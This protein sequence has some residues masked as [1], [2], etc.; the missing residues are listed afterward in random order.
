MRGCPIQLSTRPLKFLQAL[1][2]NSWAI[3]SDLYQ[4][5]PI[6]WNTFL[7]CT[8][9]TDGE[10]SVFILSRVRV[11]IYFHYHHFNINIRV[12]NISPL[13]AKRILLYLKIQF[14]PHS[15]HFSSRN[16]D[17]LSVSVM[18]ASRIDPE[19]SARNSHYTL[20]YMPAEHNAI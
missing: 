3:T 10:F 18:P 17:W 19:T 1:F 15:K 16:V 9:I 8:R 7:M 20:R 4:I 12:Y 5:L 11:P 2:S 13:K 6:F 14:V